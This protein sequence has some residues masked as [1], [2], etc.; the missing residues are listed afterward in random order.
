[1]LARPPARPPAHRHPHSNNQVSPCENL[2]NN[3]RENIMQEQL[4]ALSL[5]LIFNTHCIYVYFIA[6]YGQSDPGIKFLYLVVSCIK[7]K[8]NLTR[9]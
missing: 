2:V 7:K 8:T 6:L 3:M 5:I 9:Y 1:M 4:F